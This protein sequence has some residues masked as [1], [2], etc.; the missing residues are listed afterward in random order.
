M[1]NYIGNFTKKLDSELFTFFVT[2][3]NIS[4]YFKQGA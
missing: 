1:H 4:P 2:I 3:H